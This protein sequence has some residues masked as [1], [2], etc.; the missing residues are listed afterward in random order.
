MDG[1]R[2]DIDDR[3]LCHEIMKSYQALM[4]ESLLG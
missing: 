3:N 2:S 4:I 1:V